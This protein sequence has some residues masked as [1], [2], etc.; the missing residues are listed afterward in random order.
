MGDEQIVWTRHQQS[1]Q[2]LRIR[3]RI[4]PGPEISLLKHH[5][6]AVMYRLHHLVRASGDDR[7]GQLRAPILFFTA[8]PE[9]RRGE[10]DSVSVLYIVRLARLDASVP[11][12]EAIQEDKTPL[13][14]KRAPEHGF[15][16]HGLAA[17]IDLSL[18]RVLHP[19]RC[20]SPF[21]EAGVELPLC[22]EA[23]DDPILGGTEVVPVA[24][25]G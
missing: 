23:H 10:P 18:A 24:E 16:G 5:R 12:I 21:R 3:L 2:G 4:E 6:H 1:L 20:K 9:S 17:S 15:L 13:A 11:F 14:L 25:R 7:V 19:S 8:G 22:V